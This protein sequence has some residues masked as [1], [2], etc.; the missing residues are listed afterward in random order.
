[1][2]PPVLQ[3]VDQRVAHLA[4]RAEWTRVV[5]ICPYRTVASE[6][7]IHGFGDAHREPLASPDETV[8]AVRLNEKMDVISLH[9]E[10]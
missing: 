4:R 9:A 1:M 3:H 10:V 5:A 7:A 2:L 8:R 6:D